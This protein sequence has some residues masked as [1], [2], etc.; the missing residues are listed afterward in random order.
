MKRTGCCFNEPS[1]CLTVA[2]NDDLSMVIGLVTY[3][4]T[5][6]GTGR[7]LATMASASRAASVL[8]WFHSC[9]LPRRFCY[10]RPLCV[11]RHSV[12]I[13]NSRWPN[14]FIWPSVNSSCC[15]WEF[16]VSLCDKKFSIQHSTFS[17]NQCFLPHHGGRKRAGSD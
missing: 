5:A 15:L 17:I 8:H 14:H 3:C 2:I 13:T 7:T 1:G 11:F 10:R 12:N 6:G 9:R 16:L 4:G